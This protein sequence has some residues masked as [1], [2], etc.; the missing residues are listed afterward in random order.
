MVQELWREQFHAKN[1]QI[2]SQTL[3]ASMYDFRYGSPTT[4][5]GVPDLAY[6][7]L[8]LLDGGEFISEVG[9]GDWDGFLW[10]VPKKRKC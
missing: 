5:T 4:G 6:S 8:P 9:C 10:A 7:P 2:L 3:P 1:R